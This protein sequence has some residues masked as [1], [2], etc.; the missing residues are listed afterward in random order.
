MKNKLRCLVFLLLT[1][2]CSLLAAYAQAPSVEKIDPP[3][4]WANMTINPVRILLRG[5]NLNAKTV[6]T[7]TSAL[8]ASNIKA[9]A[10]GNY[11]FF[12]LT[13]AKNAKPGKYKIS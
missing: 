2:H 9:S 11:L 1:A 5:K 6:W 3:S 4:W 10:N 13:I 7:Y 8:K 12:D